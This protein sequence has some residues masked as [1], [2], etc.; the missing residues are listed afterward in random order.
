MELGPFCRLGV[1]ELLDGAACRVALGLELLELHHS[2]AVPDLGVGAL[3]EARE[4]LV[5]ELL[6]VSSSALWLRLLVV[7]SGLIQIAGIL[8]FFFTMW[9]RIRGVGSQVREA[10]GERF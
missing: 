3:V 10:R 7:A 4:S 1:A 5:G 6:R 2:L 9:S 8:V